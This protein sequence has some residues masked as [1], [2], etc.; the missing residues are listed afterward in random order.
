[1]NHVVAFRAWWRCD[2]IVDRNLT[3]L[4]RK[5]EARP[6]SPLPREP[7]VSG[8]NLF[9]RESLVDMEVKTDEGERDCDR[10]GVGIRVLR[11]K[12]IDDVLLNEILPGMGKR[13][14]RQLVDML[15]RRCGSSCCGLTTSIASHGGLERS[16][17][18][19]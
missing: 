5:L 11:R 3:T 2:N 19:V 8:L 7:H 15:P 10:L 17:R 9:P 1:M 14:I 4:V 13:V 12:R 18:V 16:Q 6:L